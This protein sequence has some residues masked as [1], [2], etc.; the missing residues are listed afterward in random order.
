MSLADQKIGKDF[1]QKIIRM[2]NTYRKLRFAFIRKA[3]P[4]M[5]R[6]GARWIYAETEGYDFYGSIYRNQ[7][8]PTP[9]YFECK[10]TVKPEIEIASPYDKD[11]R[12][13]DFKQL[14]TLIELQENG[15]KAFILWEIRSLQN[16]CLMLNPKSLYLFIGKTIKLKGLSEH[17]HYETIYKTTPQLDFLGLLP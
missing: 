7:G 3:N 10:T 15:D 8:H 11:S 16:K 1:E 13:I 14:M 2:S 9:V 4:R 6:Q 12:G 17:K 5:V